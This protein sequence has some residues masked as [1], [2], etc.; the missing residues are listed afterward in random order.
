VAYKR[1]RGLKSK[2]GINAPRLR[3]RTHIPWPLR[4]LAIG[5]L[6]AAGLLLGQ[7]VFETGLRIA[8]FEKGRAQEKMAQLRT[9]V[10]LLEQE[11]TDL[12]AEK[13]RTAQQI[14]IEQTTQKDL[15]KSLQGIQEENVTL[16]E[17]NAF[18]RNLLSPDQGPGPIT[19]YHFK[20][21]RNPLLAGEYRYRLLLLKSGKREQEF[22]GSVQFLVTGEQAGK[23]LSLMQ[24]DT[25]AAP[26]AKAK[27]PGIGVSFKYYQ[28]LEGSFQLPA[29]LTPKSVQVRVFEA[30]TPQPKW[31]KTVTL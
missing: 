29:G 7:W 23:K 13:L 31:T 28:R 22:V 20:L 24:P 12:K 4:M 6:V 8:G 2:F 30:G 27:L 5:V 10:S 11:N 9:Q 17:D 21:E 14:E 15:A 1:F 3:V 26:G 16:R 18:F 25:S 19:I